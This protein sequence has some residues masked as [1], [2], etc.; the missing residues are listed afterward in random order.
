MYDVRY[1]L[2]LTYGLVTQNQTAEL[3]LKF[4]KICFFLIDKTELLWAGF[5][6]GCFSLGDCEAPVY[7]SG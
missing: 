4:V 5:R 3:N 2:S 6:R 7:N 1:C